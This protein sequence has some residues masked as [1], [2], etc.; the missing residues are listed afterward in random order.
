MSAA[1]S[2]VSSSTYRSLNNSYKLTKSKINRKYVNGADLKI[3]GC[4]QIEFKIGGR[5]MSH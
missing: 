1:V 4:T 2:L 3:E 5:T